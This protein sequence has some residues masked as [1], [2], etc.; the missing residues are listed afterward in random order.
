M[1]CTPS[2]IVGC[3]TPCA[4]VVLP[5]GS[6]CCCRSRRPASWT[7]RRSG[8]SS[9]PTPSG[10]PQIRRS[11][12]LFTDASTRPTRRM[13]RLRNPRGAKLTRH[14][15]TPSRWSPLPPMRWKPRTAPANST[16][17]CV[18]GSTSP[19]ALTC[20]GFCLTSGLPAAARCV[21]STAARLTSAWTC[22]APRT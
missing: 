22:R 19:L 8:G 3:M 7:A 18:T 4:T 17:F 15:G 14:W 13:I 21:R 10:V 1:R 5:G 11:T 2:V 9:G 20:G 12:R 16:R 6:R